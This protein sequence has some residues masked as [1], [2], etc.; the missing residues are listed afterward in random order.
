MGENVEILGEIEIGIEVLISG[1]LGWA[2]H[3]IEWFLRRT[4]LLLQ[5]WLR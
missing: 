5:G 2:T 3:N 4:S 1:F